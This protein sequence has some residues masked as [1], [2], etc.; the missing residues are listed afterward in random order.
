MYFFVCDPDPQREILKIEGIWFN[1]KVLLIRCHYSSLNYSQPLK[2]FIFSHNDKF[3]CILLAFYLLD[4]HKI[5]HTWKIKE[6]SLNSRTWIKC[7]GTK[8]SHKIWPLTRSLT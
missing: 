1:V 3:L 2:A 6:I 5:V 8:P 7:D 4:K